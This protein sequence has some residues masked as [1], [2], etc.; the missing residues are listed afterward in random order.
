MYL[1]KPT[2][3]TARAPPAGTRLASALSMMREP[4]LRS[5]S[6]SSP[7]AFES[8][9]ERREL[10]HT[11]SPKYGET[12]AGVIFAGFISISVTS[13]PRFASCQAHSLPASPAPMTVTFS[14]KS[15]CLA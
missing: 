7:T 1:A 14:I 12:C 3:S 4:S 11:S 15:S 5:S 2:L 10:E 6:F 13:T 9:S 8:S